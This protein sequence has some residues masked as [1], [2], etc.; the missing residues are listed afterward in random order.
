MLLP[1]GRYRA[2][3]EDYG[4]YQ[5]TAGQQLPTVFVSFQLVG[6]YDPSSGVL[7]DCPPVTR[8]YSKAISP[9]TINWVLSDLKAI[10]YDREGFRYLDPEVPGAVNLFGREIDVVA[11]HEDYEGSA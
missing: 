1:Q 4:V 3:V 5:S 10:G 6:R 2:R 8:T 11:D 7:G 9:K